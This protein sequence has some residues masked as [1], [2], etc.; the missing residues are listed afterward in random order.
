MDWSLIAPPKHT[1]SRKGPLRLKDL[2]EQPL[3]L[4]ER[5]STGRQHVFDAFHARGLTPRVD[6]EM[7]NTEV[8]VRMVEAG[9]GVSIVPL[10]PSGA[11]TRGRK[12]A[13]RSLGGQIRPI[14]SGVLT[15][16]GEKL[17]EAARRLLEFVKI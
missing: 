14:D 12:I 13:V 7:T 1:L 17:P 16:K 5:G 4:F 9:L 3:I 11:V 6:M 2:A 8:I 15:R 10:L